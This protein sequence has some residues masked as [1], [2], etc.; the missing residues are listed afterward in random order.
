[1]SKVD[2]SRDEQEVFEAHDVLSV[3]QKSLRAD[4]EEMR[5]RQSRL[6]LSYQGECLEK[7]LLDDMDSAQEAL[8]LARAAKEREETR[9]EKER[10]E[11]ESEQH[12]K[13]YGEN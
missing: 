12:C 4:L 11:R 3:G 7:K 13:M 5:L 6:L 2:V 10:L 9:L 8:E 1:M